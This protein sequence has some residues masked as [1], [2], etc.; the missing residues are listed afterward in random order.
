MKKRIDWEKVNWDEQDVVIADQFGC[1][2]ERVRQK[3]GELG[4]CKAKSWHCRRESLK[5]DIRSLGDTSKMTLKEI[6]E[7]A[8]CSVSYALQ[9][10]KLAHKDYLKQKK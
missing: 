3:R 5:V 8:G 2:R 7:K 4:K 6:A 1:S 10:L 9:C